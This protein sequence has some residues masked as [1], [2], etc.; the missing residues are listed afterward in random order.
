M[1]RQTPDA[2]SAGLVL[3][4]PVMAPVAAII[5]ISPAAALVAI[6][7]M[8]VAVVM[9]LIELAPAV[10]VVAMTVALLITRRIF[11]LVPVVL[12]KK[13]ALAAGLVLMAM[14]APVPGVAGRDAQ[15]Q[16]RANGE[17]QKNKKRQ[18]LNQGWGREAGK[19]EPAR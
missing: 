12:H 11:A 18:A 7:A 1:I 15:I 14:F 16:R 13:H 2:L 5:P 9:T 3:A 17:W 4:A 19:V 6:M 8:V 10:V